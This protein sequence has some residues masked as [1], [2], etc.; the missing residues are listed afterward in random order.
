MG[1]DFAFPNEKGTPGGAGFQAGPRP[2]SEPK[3][4]SGWPRE[5]PSKMSGDK[6]LGGDKQCDSLGR[7]HEYVP[8][9]ASRQIAR[10]ASVNGSLAR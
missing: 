6:W 8:P 7:L 9:V 4:P 5:W 2:R 3:G 1:S 10:L